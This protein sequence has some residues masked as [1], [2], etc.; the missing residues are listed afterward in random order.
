MGCLRWA[1]AAAFV[2]G[3]EA[4]VAFVLVAEVVALLLDVVVATASLP[5]PFDD[6]DAEG[7]AAFLHIGH[8]QALASWNRFP[9]SK[10]VIQEA[11]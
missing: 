4:L 7:G 1:A 8:S 9:C 5:L 2:D 6:A 3:V 11:G 10:N